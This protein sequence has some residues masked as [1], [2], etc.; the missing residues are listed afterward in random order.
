[1]IKRRPIP[2]R[3]KPLPPPEV[4]ESAKPAPA[5]TPPIDDILPDDIRKMIEAAYS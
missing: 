5:Q 3:Q 2:K 1:M 4:P